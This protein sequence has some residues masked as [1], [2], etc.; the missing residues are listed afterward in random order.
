M[1]ILEIIEGCRLSGSSLEDRLAAIGDYP[2][3]EEARLIRSYIAYRAMEINWLLE[4]EVMQRKR[5]RQR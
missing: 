5:N 3:C 4:L 1:T 2:D